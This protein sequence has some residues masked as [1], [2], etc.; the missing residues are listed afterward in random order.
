[1][2]GALLPRAWHSGT[3]PSISPLFS[4]C[5]GRSVVDIGVSRVDCAG[6]S[7]SERWVEMALEIGK[8][9][10]IWLYAMVAAQNC[11]CLV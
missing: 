8:T 6:F 9:V 5:G 7:G 4:L 1:V 3:N 11:G 2:L 10:R